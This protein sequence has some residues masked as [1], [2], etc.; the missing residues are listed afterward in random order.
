MEVVCIKKNLKK[1]V[2]NDTQK[3]FQLLFLVCKKIFFIKGI[4]QNHLCTGRPIS[5]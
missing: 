2:N 4:D 5:E 3:L 1:K